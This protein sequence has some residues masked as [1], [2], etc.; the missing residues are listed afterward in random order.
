MIAPIFDGSG[1]KTKVAEA[2]MYGKKIIGTPEAFSGYEGVADQAGWV[3]ATANEFVAAI[4]DAESEVTQP[5]YPELR[6]LYE[7]KY[8]FSAAAT[9]L[10][11]ILADDSGL[12]NCR[13]TV[14]NEKMQAV[15]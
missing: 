9:R 5:F 7:E 12:P 15:P 14:S 10:A 3:C 6:M 1:M 4:A 8:S 11:A 13:D 2:L